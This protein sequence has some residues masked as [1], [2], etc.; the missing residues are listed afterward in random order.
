M[1]GKRMFSRA[2]CR[3]DV[4]LDMPP[5]AQCLY[6]QL[7]LDADDDGFIASPRAV[8]RLTGASDSDMNILQEN[9]FIFQ[10]SSGKFLIVHWKVHNFLAKDRYAKSLHTEERDSVYVLPSESYSLTPGE[11]AISLNLINNLTYAEFVKR[12]V[13]KVVNAP[14]NADKISKEKVRREENSIADYVSDIIS[15]YK[16]CASL[17]PLQNLNE[18]AITVSISALLETYTKEDI[19]SAIKKANASPFLTGKTDVDF[20]ANL[21]WILTPAHITDILN[22]KYDDCSTTTGESDKPTIRF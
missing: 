5:I 13:N 19:L 14:V 18:T 1:A 16:E 21:G 8:M 11:D 6:I 10:F 4:F 22:G 3:D 12:N 20:R 7:C 9:N 2:F 15:A 17:P